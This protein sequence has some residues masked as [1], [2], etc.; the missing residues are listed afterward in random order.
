MQVNKRGEKMIITRTPFR[1][2]FVGGGT[3]LKSFYQSGHGA[4]VS[5]AINKYMYISIHK[6]FDN[7]IL[8]KYSKTELV[9]KVDN[10][11]HPLIREAMKLT[12]VVKGV[13]IAS[14]SDIP[15]GTG[16]ASS[17]SFTVGLLHALYAYR[18]K[19]V[20]AERLAREAAHIEINLV[21]SP[22]GKQDQYAAAFG[23][24]NYIQFNKDESVLVHP[25]VFN[26][27]KELEKN[28][29]LFYTGITR[30][31]N[32][33][34]KEQSKITEKNKKFEQLVKMRDLTKPLIKELEKGNIE[35]IGEMLHKNWLMKRSL[36][37]SISNKEIDK[38]YD[39][40]LNAGAKGGKLLGAGGGGFL[41]FYC[42]LKNQDRLRK[43]LFDL[44]EVP[45]CFDNEGSRIIYVGE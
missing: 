19:N 7:K 5:T 9:E 24:F 20:S 41:L 12:G 34:L 17:S 42:D 11:Q 8:L 44:K 1:I 4:V 2:S 40:A 23:G 29:L 43:D 10:I 30:S 32:N 18:G 38:L 3:D 45:F 22:I 33:I 25:I 16:L 14:I 26:K 21:G 28:L 37:S 13:E 39:K 27:K 36:T 6:Y 15:A 31:A 35:V